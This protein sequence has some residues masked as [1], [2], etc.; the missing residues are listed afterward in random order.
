MCLIQNIED[1]EMAYFALREKAAGSKKSFFELYA[2]MQIVERD[3]T[4][5][6]KQDERS[7]RVMINQLRNITLTQL[8][9]DLGL[10]EF[11]EWKGLGR[12]P[13]GLEAMELRRRYNAEMKGLRIRLRQAASNRAKRRLMRAFNKS[14]HGFVVLHKETPSTVLL[15]EK[16]YGSR[17]PACWA[18]CMPFQPNEMS[19]QKLVENTKTVALTMRALLTLYGRVPMAADRP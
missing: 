3:P 6:V 10:P 13:K 9:S 1:L 15:V 19:V 18:Q 5:P 2:C 14:K 4:K 12:A 7:A 16:A 11:D 8:R 17:G